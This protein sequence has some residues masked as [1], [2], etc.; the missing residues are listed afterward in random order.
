VFAALCI[1]AGGVPGLEAW[2]DFNG[3]ERK[4]DRASARWPHAMR[5]LESG[6]RGIGWILCMGH[7]PFVVG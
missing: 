5:P 1:A 3:W 4:A 2:V 6:T 7:Q